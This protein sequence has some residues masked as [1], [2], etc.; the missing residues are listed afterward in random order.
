MDTRDDNFLINFDKLPDERT[1]TSLARMARLAC[2]K[3]A[4]IRPEF[5]EL[6][7]IFETEL[8]SD[9]TTP[10]PKRHKTS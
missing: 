2:Q 7:E 4:S 1:D 9:T 6:L 5:S 8:M 3:N 10:Q